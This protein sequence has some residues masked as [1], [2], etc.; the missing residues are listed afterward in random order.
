M[1]NI[2]GTNL[3]ASVKT[4]T[5]QVAKQMLSTCRRN[6]RVEMSRV[7]RL[8][9]ARERDEW[10]IAQPILINCDGT[11]IDGQ[12]RLRMVVHTGLPTQFLVISGYDRD[13]TFARID[14]IQTR[15]LNHWLQIQGEP[16]PEIMATVIKMAGRR[17]A[18][19]IPTGSG[20]SFRQTG[21]E[22]IEFLEKHP[23][24]RSSVVDAPAT[25]NRLAPRSLLCFGHYLFA[26]K[27]RTLADSFLVDLVTGDKEAAGD[28][29]YQLRERLKT[30][31]HAKTKITR[32]EM[33]ALIIK[34]WNA[35]RED[36]KLQNLRW[37][38]TGPQAEAFPEVI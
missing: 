23:K 2:K 37:R 3:T 9:R 12:H 32:T 38:N 29:I 27:D 16:L 11:L 36:R 31:R 6:R 21:P 24:I 1:G 26:Q 35:V 28:P 15:R 34:A 7:L 8:S 10:V 33:L 22:G 18:G 14:D 20:G 13:Q 30:N 5:P 25:V 19:L 17:E 4:I